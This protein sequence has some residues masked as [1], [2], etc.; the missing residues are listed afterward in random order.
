MFVHT[1]LFLAQDHAAQL[2]FENVELADGL[3]QLQQHVQHTRHM[4]PTAEHIGYI[5][6]YNCKTSTILVHSQHWIAVDSHRRS[7]SGNQCEKE[8]SLVAYGQLCTM[9]SVLAEVM[10]RGGVSFTQIPVFFCWG[11]IGMV[12]INV[13]I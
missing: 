8:T 5:V 11:K 10:T 9:A 4:Q 3:H 6:I 13:F 2:V 7:K 12:K 1:F